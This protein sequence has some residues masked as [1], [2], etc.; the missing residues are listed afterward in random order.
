MKIVVMCPLCNHTQLEKF[1]KTSNGD[2]KYRCL[3]CHTF[4]TNHALVNSIDSPKKNF[5]LPEINFLASDR[6]AKQA[7]L[8]QFLTESSTDKNAKLKAGIRSAIFFVGVTL[9]NAIGQFAIKHFIKNRVQVAIVMAVLYQ[10]V[11]VAIIAHQLMENDSG[12]SWDRVFNLFGNY[13]DASNYIFLSQYGYQSTGKGA[14]YIV[15]FP[16]YPIL[17]C[18]FTPLLGNPYLAGVVISNIGSIIGHAAFAMYL[19]EAGFQEGKVWRIMILLFLTP[20]SVYFSIIYT[21][22][23]FLATTALFLYFL[24]KRYYS[25]AAIAGFGAALTRSLGILCIIPYLVHFIENKLWQTKKYVLVKSLVIPLGSLIY[26]GINAWM[27]HDP[28][29]YKVFMKNIW[30]KEVGNPLTHYIQ[31]TGS[32]VKGD[33]LDS[34]T[35][36]IDQVST[37]ILPIV[38]L[39]YLISM[40]HKS[41]KI[42]Y[43]LLSWTIAQWVVIASQ[44][45]WLSNTRYIG[46]ILPFY[47]MLEE[48][49]GKFFIS[50]AIMAIAFGGLAL[51][52]IKLFSIGAWL[53]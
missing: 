46:L 8:L 43:G 51:Y 38:V 36:Y 26:L 4:F 12:L 32:L 39:L 14:E 7:L 21:E 42:P 34:I 2:R 40:L 24:Q 47:I 3:A 13:W 52:A 18:L 27:F 19:L 35:I 33:W 50:Y 5:W 11:L 17:I 22:G 45:F 28:F 16:F 23:V 48:I 25:L 6:Y 41:K 1:G 10:I 53:Y 9:K 29:H 37:V 30:H 15:F 49:I 20:I 31:N 44:S